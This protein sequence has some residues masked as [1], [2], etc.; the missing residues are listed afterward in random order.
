MTCYHPLDAWRHRDASQKKLLFAYHPAKC[1][2]LKPDLQVPCGQCVGCRLERSRQWA[3][4]C[5]HEAQLYEKNCF[6]TLTYNNEHLPKDGSL[7][8]EHYQKFMKRLRRKYGSQIRFF[9]CGEYGETYG[10]PHYHACLF[11]FDFPDKKFWK[12]T[13]Q[14]DRLYTS[15]S[16]QA[17]W[18]DPDTQKPMGFCSIGDVTFQSA[19]YVAR[20]IMKKINGKD[21]DKHYRIV[22]HSTGEITGYRKPE[23]VTMSRRPGLGSG[24]YEK[25]KSEVFP[26]DEVVMNGKKIQPPKFY[27]SRLEQQNPYEFDELKFQREENAKLHLDNNTPERLAIREV[28]HNARISFLKRNVE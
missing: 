7:Q 10:R 6:I 18:S 21:A 27:L 19:A 25:Y 4:R 11:N 12:Q 3:I 24:W 22:D 9:H 8:L 14:G 2:S 20:Y 28:V 5:V 16:L 13:P 17:L 23:Y 26:S 1:N 15:D